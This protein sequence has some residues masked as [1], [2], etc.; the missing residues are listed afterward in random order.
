MATAA[1]ELFNN[2]IGRIEKIKISED[3]DGS[4]SISILLRNG[5]D[6]I[7]MI[8]G[9]CIKFSNNDEIILDSGIATL[10]H[11]AG[12]DLSIE[13]ISAGNANSILIP[14]DSGINL[15]ASNKVKIYMKTNKRILAK[16]YD[17][18]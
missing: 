1:A 2:T 15:L 3:A 13:M 4:K 10:L 18:N 5:A 11:K 12:I 7:S 14:V 8:Q 16:T 17:L 9:N 6:A